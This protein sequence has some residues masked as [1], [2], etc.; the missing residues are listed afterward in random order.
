VF[1]SGWGD[2]APIW[3]IVQPEVAKWTRACREVFDQAR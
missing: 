2:W 1:D 3:M